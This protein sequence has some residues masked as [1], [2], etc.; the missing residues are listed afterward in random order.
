MAP[1]PLAPQKRPLHQEPAV[2]VTG[3]AVAILFV[4]FFILLAQILSS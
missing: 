3:A 2:L 1:Q 4:V